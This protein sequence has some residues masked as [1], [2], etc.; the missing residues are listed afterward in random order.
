MFSF[1]QSQEFNQLS[2]DAMQQGARFEQLIKW[3]SLVF[4]LTRSKSY[5]QNF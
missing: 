5:W 3:K 2:D 4:A 1:V